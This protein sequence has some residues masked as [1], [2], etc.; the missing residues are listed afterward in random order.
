[1][2]LYFT[3]LSYII[4][5]LCADSRTDADVWF[6]YMEQMVN[7]EIVVVRYG[8]SYLKRKELNNNRHPTCVLLSPVKYAALIK[9]I[10]TPPNIIT[11]NTVTF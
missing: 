2:I 4:D 5:H 3:L 11:I 10:D 8:I 6:S 1:M 9:H 7:R